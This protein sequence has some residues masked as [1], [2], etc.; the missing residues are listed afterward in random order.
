MREIPSIVQE[1]KNAELCKDDST[2]IQKNDEYNMK[3]C[4]ENNSLTADDYLDDLWF[5][6]YRIL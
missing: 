3:D 4:N 2:D 5:H 1:L 6:M